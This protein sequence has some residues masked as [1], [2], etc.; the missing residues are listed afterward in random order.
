MSALEVKFLYLLSLLLLRTHKFLQSVE[1]G[2]FKQGLRDKP[3]DSRCTCLFLYL[4][5]VVGR[6]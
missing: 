1:E 6:D 5:P 4:A 2:G 3:A